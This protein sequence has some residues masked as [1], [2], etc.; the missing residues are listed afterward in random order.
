MQSPTFP[1]LRTEHASFPAFRA[2]S[3]DRYVLDY[4]FH[5][6][7][8]GNNLNRVITLTNLILGGSILCLIGVLARVD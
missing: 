5:G 3:I 2:P 1:L 8:V 4:K 6:T 7:G